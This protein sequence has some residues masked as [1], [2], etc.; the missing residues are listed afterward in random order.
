MAGAGAMPGDANAT[1]AAAA[2]LAPGS[3]VAAALARIRERI[4]PLGDDR[5]PGPDLA[6][7]LD[8]VHSGA[9]ADLVAG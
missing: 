4:A 7:A 9:L 6:A 3:G 1:A 5:E 8:L 2:P